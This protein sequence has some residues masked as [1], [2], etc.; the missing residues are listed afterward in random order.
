MA[1]SPESHR[2][3]GS[4]R[5]DWC[6]RVTNP[7]KTSLL[8]SIP[9]RRFKGQ[10]IC[11]ECSFIFEMRISV[12]FFAEARA[13]TGI[14]KTDIIVSGSKTSCSAEEL[15]KEL[16]KKHPELNTVLKESLLAVNQEF[17]PMKALVRPADEVALITP[18]S[19]G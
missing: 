10:L 1:R 4:H 17:V 16:G 2:G 7:I 15:L 9:T 5:H 18:I 8:G 14:D 3:I 12:L 19:G 11:L 13:T 6:D